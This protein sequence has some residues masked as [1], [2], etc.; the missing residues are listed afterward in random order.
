MKSS[1]SLLLPAE[2]LLNANFCQNSTCESCHAVMDPPQKQTHISQ[3]N[4]GNTKKCQLQTQ[5][6]VTHKTAITTFTFYININITFTFHSGMYNIA[7]NI[8]IINIFITSHFPIITF[9]L[10][11]STVPCEAGHLYDCPSASCQPCPAGSYQPQWGQVGSNEDNH[12]H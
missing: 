11:L 10:S 1:S 12:D 8:D 9:P 7:Y 4:D 5:G 2:C 6:N 3:N